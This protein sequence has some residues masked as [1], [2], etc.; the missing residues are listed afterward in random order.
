[1]DPAGYQRDSGKWEKGNGEANG[2]RTIDVADDGVKVDVGINE[3]TGFIAETTS[4]MGALEVDRIFFGGG[5]ERHDVCRWF[6]CIG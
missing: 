4:E 6:L 3:I 2:K 1:M 5:V